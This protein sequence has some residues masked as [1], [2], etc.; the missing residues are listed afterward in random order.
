M[1]PATK[2]AVIS[3]LRDFATSQLPKLTKWTLS[4]IGQAYPFHRLFFPDREILAARVER[5]VVTSMGTTL[6]PSLA[7]AICKGRFDCVHVE[8]PIEG[9]VNDAAINMIEQIVTELRTSPKKRE[10]PRNPDHDAEL[11]DILNSRGGGQASRSVTADLYVGDFDC[12]PLFIE[13]KSPLPNLDVAAESKRK[14]LYYLTIMNRQGKINP[15]AFL[16]LTY[17]P[18][19][20]R[21][22]YG[23]SYTKQIM[24]MRKQ[25]LIGSE[26]WDYLGGPGTYSELLALIEQVRQE[27]PG[28]ANL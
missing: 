7:E 11:S 24:D 12:G 4:D 15:Q 27:L 25:V 13:L 16:V 20:T 8:H 26:L 3:I 9:M 22:Q 6:Y 1:N 23:H 18:F 10:Y 5:S 2:N 14:L 28:L 19:I 21:E 17:N